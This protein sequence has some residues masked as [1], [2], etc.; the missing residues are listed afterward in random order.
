LIIASLLPA[1][2]YGG[3]VVESCSNEC[4]WVEGPNAAHCHASGAVDVVLFYEAM[5]PHVNA[6]KGQREVPS[7]SSNKFAT[8]HA[9]C[10]HVW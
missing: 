6:V 7:I 5:R 9:P 8:M 10:M 4:I 2:T 1:G 3:N